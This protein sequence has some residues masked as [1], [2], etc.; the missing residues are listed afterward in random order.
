MLTVKGHCVYVGPDLV[1]TFSSPEAARAAE[2]RFYALR[3]ATVADS[4]EFVHMM[5][6]IRNLP[7]GPRAHREVP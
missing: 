4:V 2:K 6:N 5:G 7:D 1:G 3:S